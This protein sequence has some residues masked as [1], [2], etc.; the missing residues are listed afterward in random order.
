MATWLDN[1]IV[2]TFQNRVGFEFNGG[3]NRDFDWKWKHNTDLIVPSYQK[4]HPLIYGQIF[5]S[6]WVKENSSDPIY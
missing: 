4:G 1:S 2:G 5:P 6:N 3:S